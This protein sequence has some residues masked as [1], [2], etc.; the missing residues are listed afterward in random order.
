MKAQPITEEVK[1]DW[2]LLRL[3]AAYDPKKFYK[4]RPLLHQ[5]TCAITPLSISAN[6][7]TPSADYLEVHRAV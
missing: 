7:R 2:R 6:F 1:R 4:V 5:Y 3:R